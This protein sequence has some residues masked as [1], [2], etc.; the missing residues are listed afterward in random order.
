MFTQVESDATC[1]L[2][3]FR[4]PEWQQFINEHPHDFHYIPGYV[5][6]NAAYDDAQTLAFLFEENGSYFFFPFL[7]RRIP[8]TLS[9]GEELYDAVTPYGYTGPLTNPDCDPVFIN[10][11]IRAL[12]DMLTKL[13]VVTLFARLHPLYPPSDAF[14]NRDDVKQHG[15]TVS[16]DLTLTP[17]EMMK[18]TR[19]GHRYEI[20][21]AL[22]E[23]QLKTFVDSDF[24]HLDEFYNIYETTMNRLGAS[25][26]YYFSR[27]YLRKLKD[28]LGDAVHLI[29]VVNGDNTIVASS[30]FTE[31][32]GIVQYHLSGSLERHYKIHPSKLMLHE[33][34]LWARERG[35]Q[36][37]HL[38]GG[39][40]GQEDTLYLF[41]SG[42][43][44]GRHPFYTWRL[45]ANQEAYD[46]LVDRWS[47]L[48]S[49]HVPNGFFP[50]YAQRLK[51][52]Q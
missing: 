48:A 43:G 2:L 7:L 24:D 12:K 50:A 1:Q 11:A 52:I 32:S 44:K 29:H 49:N 33:A 18:E 35:N 9:P 19:K 17:D 23:N 46:H 37:F 26:F 42:F 30:V 3:L 51:S 13:K 14:L 21:K 40:G 34:R 8:D 47:Q 20:K 27:P 5:A 22:R 6:L 15:H 45:V 36:I 39:V 10:R 31:N 16:V 28:I 25:H 4:S 41:K 38:G